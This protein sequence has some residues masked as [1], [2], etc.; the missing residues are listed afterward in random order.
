MDGLTAGRIV[1]Y[2]LGPNNVDCREPLA[3]RPAIVVRVC[4][5]EWGYAPEEGRVNLQVFTD[6]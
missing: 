4:P 6:A 5:P 1:H 3:H 2:V